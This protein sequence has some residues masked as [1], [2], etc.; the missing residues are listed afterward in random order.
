MSA[1]VVVVARVC[2]KIRNVDEVVDPALYVGHCGLV[3][4]KAP[5][6]VDNKLERVLALLEIARS[7]AHRLHNSQRATCSLFPF[8]CMCYWGNMEGEGYHGFLVFTQVTWESLRLKLPP[9]EE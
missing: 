2:H 1:E 4:G 5:L 3:R 8:F 9:Y 7:G 6:V